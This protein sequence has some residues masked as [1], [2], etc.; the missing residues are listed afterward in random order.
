MARRDR[1]ALRRARCAESPDWIRRSE[2]RF[3]LLHD[4]LHRKEHGADAIR[5]RVVLGFASG[6]LIDRY[7][8]D[9]T[10]IGAEF[11]TGHP[12]LDTEVRHYRIVFQ[13]VR[14]L[15]LDPR[16]LD[17]TQVG[18]VARHSDALRDGSDDVKASVP[19]L[20]SPVI[21]DRQRAD[22]MSGAR[23]FLNVVR[24]YALDELPLLIREWLQLP[25]RRFPLGGNLA[26]REFEC[27]LIGGRESDAATDRRLI[28]ASVESG[29]ELIH[30]LAEF[31][32]RA[33]RTRFFRGD[34]PDLLDR[35]SYLWMQE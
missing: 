25:G 34:H 19:V 27:L 5:E 11:R 4:P 7:L 6:R 9:Q 32:T 29:A 33:A 18:D 17:E 2:R 13:K 20:P 31:E 12:I 16:D 24:L 21:E 26:D 8:K 30:H 22:D 3:E 15:V 35:A 10:L 28:D 23:G 1:L 14:G